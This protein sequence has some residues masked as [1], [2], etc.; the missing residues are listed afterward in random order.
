MSE[1]QVLSVQFY[2]DTLK[3]FFEENEDTHLKLKLSKNRDNDEASDYLVTNATAILVAA[4]KQ[5]VEEEQ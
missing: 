2:D 5:I 3:V 4:L 1:E